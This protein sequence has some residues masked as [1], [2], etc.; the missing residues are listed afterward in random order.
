MRGGEKKEKGGK[1]GGR[2]ERV[3]G[4]REIRETAQGTSLL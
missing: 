3:E 2:G 4:G 1:R